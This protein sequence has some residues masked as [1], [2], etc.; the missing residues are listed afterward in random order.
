MKN[1]KTIIV[2][3]AISISMSGCI[4]FITGYNY[5]LVKVYKVVKMGTTTYMT[6]EEIKELRLDDTAYVI[7]SGYEIVEMGNEKNSSSAE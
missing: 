7:E 4:G 5:D 1:I 3:I 6:E 2:A